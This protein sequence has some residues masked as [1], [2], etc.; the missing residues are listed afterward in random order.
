MPAIQIVVMGMS[1]GNDPKPIK[2]GVINHE[3]NYSGGCNL[4]EFHTIAGECNIA[5]LS[6]RYL[7]TLPPDT[8]Y[9]VGFHLIQLDTFYTFFSSNYKKIMT[10][11]L[12]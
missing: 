6:C 11:V 9:L 3:F 10:H 7:S 4:D 12:D 2:V 5:N 8:I 1:M